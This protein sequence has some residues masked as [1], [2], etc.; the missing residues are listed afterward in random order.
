M[1][2]V[3]TTP[4]TQP[5]F[6]AAAPIHQALADKDLLPAEHRLDAGYVDSALLVD[7]QADN[8]HVIGPVAPDHSW[9]ALTPAAHDI[10]HFH[11]DWEHQTVSCP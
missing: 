9:Q 1:T 5:D 8:I 10:A 2:N 7:G 3:L 4:A 6:V 11:I